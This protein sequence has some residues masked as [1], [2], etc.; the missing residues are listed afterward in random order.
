MIF[1][2]LKTSYGAEQQLCVHQPELRHARQ[3][4]W[5]FL[6]RIVEQVQDFHIVQVCQSSR[7]LRNLVVAQRKT[8]YILHGP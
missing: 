4:Y 8:G 6:E 2:I 5:N 3:R 7:D 1:E